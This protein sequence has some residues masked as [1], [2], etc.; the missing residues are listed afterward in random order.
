VLELITS[1]FNWV[2]GQNPAHVWTVAGMQLPCCQRC[3]GLYWGA[4]TG[5]ILDGLLRPEVRKRFLLVQAGFILQLGLFALPAFPDSGVLRMMS[6]VFY[7]CAVT[8]L[9]TWSCR[10][11]ADNYTLGNWCSRGC[12]PLGYTAGLALCLA[13]TLTAIISDS[14]WGALFLCAGIAAGTL[15]LASLAA[16]VVAVNLFR[17]LCWAGNARSS[18]RTCTSS[19][20]TSSSTSSIR[21]EKRSL[22]NGS[23]K[24]GIRDNG[25]PA[26]YR[27]FRRMRTVLNRGLG[28]L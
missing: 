22:R 1:W 23:T 21:T 5:V 8:G 7:G 4:L 17:G 6:G 13:V 14:R 2:C 19:S 28:L 27:R 25:A 26:G 16:V 15:S 12:V 18:Q 20:R 24:C 9:L 3:T 11:D 10:L